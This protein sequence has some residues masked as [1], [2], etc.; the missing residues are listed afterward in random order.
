METL[1][2]ILLWIF[3]V[4]AIIAL[5]FA[6]MYVFGTRLPKKIKEFLFNRR[7]FWTTGIEF[8]PLDNG[9]GYIRWWNNYFLDEY[10]TIRTPLDPDRSYQVMQETR[11]YYV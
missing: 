4:F 9:P 1:I 5:I 10:R 8:S 3:I 2:G 7:I 11:K 6:C